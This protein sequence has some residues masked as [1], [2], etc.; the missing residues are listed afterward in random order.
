MNPLTRRYKL[1]FFLT[2][3]ETAS[4]GRY[5]ARFVLCTTISKIN[6]ELYA[7]GIQKLSLARRCKNISSHL[8][9]KPLAGWWRTESILASCN[10]R[11]RCS[12]IRNLTAGRGKRPRLKEVGCAKFSLHNQKSNRVSG[13]KARICSKIQDLDTDMKC[14]ENFPD[15]TKFGAATISKTASGRYFIQHRHKIQYE[16]GK[17]FEPMMGSLGV[18]LNVSI[19]F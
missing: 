9:K 19:L 5:L 18:D 2:G 3:A 16:R 12:H 10:S 8:E 1:K 4:R 17:F 14:I 13:Q 6:E 15:G 11:S 7:D